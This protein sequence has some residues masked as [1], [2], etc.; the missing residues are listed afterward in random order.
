MGADNRPDPPPD[1]TGEAL[2]EWNRICDA[3]EATGHTLKPADRSILAT[4]VRTWTISQKCY[5]HVL[6]H[7]AIMEWPNGNRGPTAEYKAFRE[8][9]PLLRGLLAELGATP[10]SRNFDQ[11]LKVAGDELEELPV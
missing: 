3:I 11:A 6:E 8:T 1:I 4:Y 9:V 5:Q 10:A 2:A 7:G